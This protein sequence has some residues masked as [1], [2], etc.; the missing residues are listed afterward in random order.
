MKPH[1]IAI[2]GAGHVGATTAYTLILKN[3]ASEIF[4][5]DIDT[6]KCEGEVR[7][8]QDMLALS[9]AEAVHNASYK[10]ARSADIIIITAGAAQKKGETRRDLTHKNTTI[11]KT[12]MAGLAP[13]HPQTNIIMVTNPVDVCTYVAQNASPLPRNQ[14]FGTGTWLDTQRL[15]FLVGQALNIAPQSVDAYVLGEHGDM[16]YTLW[17]QAYIAGRSIYDF[18]ITDD[19]LQE[20]ASKA[21][22]EAY[23]IINRKGSTYYGIAAHIADICTSII[24]NQK[25]IFPL[26][27]W[28]PPEQVCL[29]V[30]AVLDNKGAAPLVIE[31]TQKEKTIQRETSQ[32]LRELIETCQL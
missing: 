32:K 16:Q 19:Q 13:I 20:I 3:L 6:E 25:R 5:V 30:P 31:P 18:G 10:Q 9:E 24:Y 26:S 15:R 4:L 27:C 17:S 29:S 2:I 1:S 12:I 14:I 22:Q 11:I 23:E 7:D 21:K 28:H 8:L